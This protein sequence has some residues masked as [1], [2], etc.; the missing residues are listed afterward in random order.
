MGLDGATN[1]AY[2]PFT[3]K[4]GLA[5]YRCVAT[6]TLEGA[7]VKSYSAGRRNLCHW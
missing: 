2:T 3:A 5:Y 1:V 6:N 7:A 4:K